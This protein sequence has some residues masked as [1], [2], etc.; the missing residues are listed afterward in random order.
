MAS[1][2]SVSVIFPSFKS[3][4]HLLFELRFFINEMT[5]LI[6]I[7]TIISSQA[8]SGIFEFIRCY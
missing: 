4:F 5:P 6:I 7:V 1:W 2:Y 3:F 8:E